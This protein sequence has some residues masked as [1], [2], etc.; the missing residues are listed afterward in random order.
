MFRLFCDQCWVF[1]VIQPMGHSHCFVTNVAVSGHSTDGTFRM[2]C[3]Q[4]WVFIII[5]PMGLSGCF[6]TSVGFLLSFN[7]WDIQTVL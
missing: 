3:D 7:R 6:V 2:F 4:C 5:Q 1:I